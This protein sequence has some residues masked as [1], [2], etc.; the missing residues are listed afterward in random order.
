MDRELPEELEGNALLVTPKRPWFAEGV[1]PILFLRK[2][3]YYIPTTSITKSDDGAIL[4]GQ[5]NQKDVAR[6]PVAAIYGVTDSV[7]QMIVECPLVSVIFSKSPA[8]SA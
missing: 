4:I 8:T 5:H 2:P 3:V 1:H 7:R 6:I